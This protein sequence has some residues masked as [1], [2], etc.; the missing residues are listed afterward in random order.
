MYKKYKIKPGYRNP[1][2]VGI[3]QDGVNFSVF[4]RHA[5]YVELLLFEDADSPEP[6]Q[7]IPLETKNHRTFFTWHVF[8]EALPVQTWY[9]WR[10]DGSNNVCESGL[11]FDRQK[12]LLDPWARAVSDTLWDR[13]LACREEDNCQASMRAMVVADD[14]DW[15]GDKPL[16][17][18][19]QS[20]IIYEMHVG[21][22]TRHPSANVNHPGTFA[23]LI[24]KIPYL[25]QLGITHVEL[26]PIMAFDEQDVPE[27]TAKLGLKNYWGYSTHSFYSPHP[28]YCMTPDQGTHQHEFRDMVKALHKAGIGVIL[29]VVFNHTSEGGRGGPVINFKGMGNDVFYHLDP[30]DR[31][32]YRDYTGCGNTVNANHPLVT[33]FIISCLEFWVREMHVD[34]FRFDLASALT[35][36]ENGEPLQNPPVLWAIEL[37]EQL[38]D[39]KL[40][41]EA[42][43][44]AGLYQ[45]GSFPGYRWSEWNGRYRDIV[46]CF[47]RG[48]TG[49][50]NEFATR[51]CGSSD[52]YDHRGRLPLNSINFITCHDG[53][54]LHDLMS[55]NEKHNL[56][57]GEDN[58]D[59]CNNNLSYNYGVE[60]VTDDIAILSVRRKQAKNAIAILLLSQGIPMLL[61]GDEVLKSQQGNN[62]GYCQ[63]NELSWFDWRLVE[64]NKDML[65]FVRLMIELR[66]SHPSLMR[67]HFLDGKANHDEDYADVTWHGADLNEPPWDDAQ[68]R[69]L[70]FT[71]TAVEPGETD[72][73][74]MFNMSDAKVDMQLPELKGRKWYRAVD[75]SRQSPHDIVETQKQNMVCN[76]RYPVTER[77]VVV[78]E[79]RGVV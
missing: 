70:A 60:G 7:V 27:V 12:L 47:L 9:A 57:N 71:L 76:R 54:T 10:M 33:H 73:H 35:R 75:T 17:L 16:C 44:A 28:G 26:L 77:T 64:E 15:E 4:S 69:I 72:L 3:D 59:G 53:F 63:D 39:T 55:Y 42:W 68:S 13:A 23:G 41:A 36:G 78:L 37:S 52:L 61:S 32:Q 11:R 1:P 24:E 58:R 2:G 45:V 18:T 19:H 67:R 50:I 5:T 74:V 22:F 29:D 79:S 31:S 62:N 38:A 25:Q 21:G 48:D 66:K 8:I 46:R 20:C 65:R 30:A 51:L 40:I 56:A 6:F 43:D 34:G 49:V 14:Y